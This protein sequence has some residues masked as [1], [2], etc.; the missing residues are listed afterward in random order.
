MLI[1]YFYGT[2]LF[3]LPNKINLITFKNHPRV[4]THQA[5]PKEVWLQ[6]DLA[7]SI[8]AITSISLMGTISV[9]P[10]TIDRY[11]IKKLF[12]TKEAEFF[13]KTYR[14]K[15]YCWHLLDNY[16]ITSKTFY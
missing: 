12:N 8:V 1:A 3:V 7:Y 10:F 5:F 9:K 15:P 13:Q 14:L 6:L 2:I 11:K 4:F 16:R